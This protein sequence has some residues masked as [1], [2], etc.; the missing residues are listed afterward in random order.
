MRCKELVANTARDIGKRYPYFKYQLRVSHWKTRQYGKKREVSIVNIPFGCSLYCW[1]DRNPVCFSKGWY[2]LEAGISRT[3][4]ISDNGRTG[5]SLNFF[6][7][8]P[9]ESVSRQDHSPGISGR[10]GQ[11]S[12]KGQAVIMKTKFWWD[13]LKVQ[14]SKG[15]CKTESSSSQIWAVWG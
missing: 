9:R 1:S 14:A 5:P 13:S 7:R 4:S 8:A 12:L 2:N 10:R 11:G 6:F 3:Y 15:F